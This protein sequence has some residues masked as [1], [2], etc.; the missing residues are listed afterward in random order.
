MEYSFA[1]ADAMGRS[2]RTPGYPLWLSAIRS[3]L[4]L[5]LVPLAQV[6]VHATAAFCLFVEFRNWKF[7]TPVAMVAA[8]CVGLGCTFMDHVHTVSSDTFAAS[9]GVMTVVAL[10][11]WAR[12]RDGWK[13]L[14]LVVVLAAATIAVRPAYLFL[15]PWLIIAG[16]MVGVIG[17]RAWRESLLS[18]CVLGGGVAGLLVVWMLFRLVGVGDFSILPFGH[19]NLAGVLVQ[20]LS[21]EELSSLDSSLGKAVV[22]EKHRFDSTVGFAAGD[23]GATMTIESRWDN[24]SYLVVVPAATKEYGEDT[25]AN[26][27]GIAEMN[28]EI[29]RTY[30]LRYVKWILLAIRRGAWAIAADIVMHPIFLVGITLMMIGLL[31][32]CT[33]GGGAVVNFD[34]DGLRALTVIAFTYAVFK[35]GFVSLTSPPVG[36]FSDAGAI[37][38]PAWIAAVFLTWWSGDCGEESRCSANSTLPLSGEPDAG[39]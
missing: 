13:S 25:I 32:R 14:A 5:A 21:D 38:I 8:A 4:G 15:I 1:S 28:K 31:Y 16:T 6:V 37:F 29:V 22:D 2:I 17:S 18:S 30:P 26:H 36:R 9:L 20:L 39:E 23:P 7:N 34:H 24:M 33:N 11:R 12:T 3:T 19:Q 35:L 10:L 27:N